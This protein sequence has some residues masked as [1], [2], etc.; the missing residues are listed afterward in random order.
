MTQQTKHM[1][2]EMKAIAARNNDAREWSFL[3]RCDDQARRYNGVH[4]TVAEWVEVSRRY[5]A[6]NDLVEVLRPFEEIIQEGS[7]DL[8]DDTPVVVKI[9]DR[10]LDL[11]LSLASFRALQ[12]ALALAEASR[13]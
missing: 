1:Q 4:L 10:V 6:H 3:R 8:P 9:G 12:R 5:T 7:E 13:P 11:T 2:A